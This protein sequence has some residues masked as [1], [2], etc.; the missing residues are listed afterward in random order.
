MKKTIF[1]FFLVALII[2]CS[3][4]KFETVPQL[5]VVS[6]NTDIVPVNGVL[7]VTLEF[8]D[9]EG[10][11]SDSIFVIRQRLNKK[12]PVTRPPV[13]YKIPPYPVTTKGEIQV[14]LE[15]QNGLVFGINAINI[16]GSN[17]QQFER[18]TMNL[19]FYVKDAAG[20]KSDTAFVSVIVIR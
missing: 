16:P 8:T 4:D 3:K 20:N 6:T 18:D 14:D 9:K 5:R 13:P 19:K 11:V 15:Y 1:Y 12:L 17:P 10:D 7:R 2:S